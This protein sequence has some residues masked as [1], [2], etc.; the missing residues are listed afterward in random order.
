VREANL[1]AM[2]L[3]QFHNSNG[4]KLSNLEQHK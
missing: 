2:T 1:W 4:A 3:S